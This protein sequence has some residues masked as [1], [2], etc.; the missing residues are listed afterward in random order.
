MAGEVELLAGAVL[1]PADLA[2]LSKPSLIGLVLI[3]IA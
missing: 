3:H 1:G 2:K